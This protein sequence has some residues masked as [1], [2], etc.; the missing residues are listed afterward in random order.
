MKRDGRIDTLKGVLITFVV[1]GHC[2][3][4]GGGTSVVANW[5][6]LFHMPFFVFISGYLSHS[7][8]HSYWNGVL[9]VA[10]SYIVF[11]ILKG[12]MYGYSPILF[13][14]TPASMM[15]YLFVLI[16]WRTLY[17]FWQRI[18]KSVSPKIV[19][20]LNILVLMMLLG[21]GLAIGMISC[22]GKTFALSRMLVFA[23]F[24]WL[25]TMVQGKDFISICKKM[26]LW[27][28]LLIIVSTIGIIV[29]LTP[30][31]WLNVREI[32]RCVNCY[33]H[34]HQLIG[35]ISRALFYV[36]ALLISISIT[37]II[38]ENS[39]LS[40]IGKDSLKFYLFHGVI[41]WLMSYYHLPWNWWIS[42]IY[43]ILLMTSIYLFNMTKLS[44]F[45]IRPIHFVKNSLANNNQNKNG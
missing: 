23:P 17:Y 9:A 24:F 21:L 25:G 10:E 6:Y 42:I 2:L 45:I 43:F 29:Y 44:D 27:L 15:W 1:L 13:I 20:Y 12:F 5:I 7:N 14:T 30:Q 34:N 11:Q 28:A 26:P 36:M 31:N 19:V 8:S 4:W 22:I 39:I 41:L 40:R 33:E 35:I 38:C 18:T 32:V 3:L 16:I 37:R